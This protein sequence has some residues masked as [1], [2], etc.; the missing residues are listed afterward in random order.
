VT[1]DFPE[2]AAS[3]SGRG[4]IN[5]YRMPTTTARVIAHLR[6]VDTPVILSDFQLW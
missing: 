6:E 2:K 5:T 1:A 4:E 3:I